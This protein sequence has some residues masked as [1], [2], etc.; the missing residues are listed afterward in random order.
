MFYTVYNLYYIY[1]LYFQRIEKAFNHP[2]KADGNAA[3]VETVKVTLRFTNELPPT[4][5]EII[6]LCNV[7]IRR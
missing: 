1:I 7:M 4:S 5:P 6:H 3:E 2:R